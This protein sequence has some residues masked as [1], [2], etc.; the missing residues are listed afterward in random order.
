MVRAAQTFA[1]VDENA[2]K[3]VD[4]CSKPRS[5]AGA[6]GQAWLADPKTPPWWPTTCGSVYG[7]WL[8]Q[9]AMFDEALEQLAGLKPED[10]VDPASLL[11]YQA[12]VYHRLLNREPGLEAIRAVAGRR[13]AEPD[14]LRCPWPG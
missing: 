12:V 2:R 5:Q 6:A 3:L 10:V 8:V 9:Q 4:L 1:L 7:R 11:F 13:P 14:A